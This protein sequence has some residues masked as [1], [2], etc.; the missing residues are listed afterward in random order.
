MKRIIIYSICLVVFIFF[1]QGKSRA[2][3][4]DTIY[5]VN[6]NKL[7]GD[8]KKMAYGVVTW[9]MDGMGTINFEEVKINKVQSIKLFEVKTKNGVLYFGSLDT[10]RFDRVIKVVSPEDTFLVNFSDIVEIYPLKNSFWLR[11]SGKISLG[12]NYSK[13]S[14]VGTI[15]TSGNAEYRKRKSYF[16]LIFDDNNT[17]QG[18]SLTS[19]KTD[20]SF[21]WQRLFTEKWSGEVS[22]KASQN[23]SLGSKLKLEMNIIGI[24]DISYNSWNRLY[25]GAG[26]NSSRETPYNNA[27]ITNDL[28]GVFSVVWKVYKYT[29]PKL[30]VDANINFL[31]YLTSNKRYLV[32]MNLNPQIN[33]VNDDFK[34]GLSFYYNYDN[35]PPEG[36]T[37][38]TDYGFNLQLSYKFH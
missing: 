25:A 27:E 1:V 10:T 4:I 19:S 21:A 26:L 20:V 12:F 31:P 14:E 5:H 8:F 23:T 36:A 22:V 32:S 35:K 29:D 13:G 6:G 33:L 16:N 17:F 2:Q 7:T 11:T 38:K 28:A 34:I 3:K 15:T 30:W 9:K 24:H 37:A 18:D